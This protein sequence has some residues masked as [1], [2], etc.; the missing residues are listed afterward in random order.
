[1]FGADLGFFQL[2]PSGF[3]APVDVD[4]SALGLHAAR[5][6]DELVLSAPDFGELDDVVG[7]GV[8]GEDG[9][10]VHGAE[11][12]DCFGGA[13]VGQLHFGDRFATSVDGHG[14]GAGA[15]DDDG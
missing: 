11:K 9:D 7:F 6:F 15:V 14:H 12:L 10:F 3:E 13:I 1:M 4:A 2:I 5:F 8:D